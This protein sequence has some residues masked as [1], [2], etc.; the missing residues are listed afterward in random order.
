[1]SVSV[2]KKSFTI[3]GI[4]TSVYQTSRA[5]SESVAVVFLLHG[6]HGSAEDVASIATSFL[7]KEKTV[8][9]S[10]GLYVVTV[11]H[12]N[13]GGRIVEVRANNTWAEKNELHAMDM[14]SIQVGTARDI[15]FLCDFLPT[16]LFP[17]DECKIDAWGV[18]GISLGGHSTWLALS[19]DPRI[20]VGIPIIG[21]PDYMELMKY[22]A[23]SSG[24]SLEAPYMPASFS[25]LVESVDPA[26]KDFTSTKA[27][28]PFIGKKILVLSGEEDPL[29]PWVA[30]K[31][32]VERLEV[33]RA[34]S[35]GVSL[36]APYMPASFSKLVESVDPASK[37][38]TSTKAHNPFIGKKILVLSGEEDP[39]VPWVASKKFVERLEVG[40]QGSKRDI[41][42]DLV[43]QSN[44][45][46][47]RIMQKLLY[48]LSYD[49]K[50]TTE[51]WQT[52]LRKQYN[53]RDPEANP[54]GPEPNHVERG[55]KEE[56]EEP[57]LPE[58]APVEQPGQ[59]LNGKDL[60]EGESSTPIAESLSME[61]GTSETPLPE[62]A[63]GSRQS[64]VLET[65]QPATVE[66]S[67]HNEGEEEK[68]ST[69]WLDLPMLTKLESLHTLV[70]WQFQNPTRLRTI[71]K[72]DDELASWRVE[73]IGYDSKR[74]AYWFIGGERLWIQ[75]VPPKPPKSQASKR[76]RVNN[77]A[78]DKNTPSKT[79]PPPKKRARL[80]EANTRSNVAST[81]GRH[82]RAA[83]DQA[84]IKLDL[85]AKE[86][87]QLNREATKLSH[88]SKGSSPSKQP[89]RL[90]SRVVGTR[91]S[92]RLRGPLEDEWQPIPNEWLNSP[93]K[94]KDRNSVS[95]NLKTG[96]ESDEESDLT[97]LSEDGEGDEDEEEEPAEVSKPTESAT[98]NGEVAQNHESKVSDEKEQ[99][100]SQEVPSDFIEW[101]TLCVTLQEWEHIAERFANATYY[102]E[103]ALYKLL[104]N[105]IVPVIT[106]ELREIERKRELEE[107]LNH[108]KRSSRLAL[109]E[110]E[111]EEARLTAMRK[112][113][114]DEKFSRT[115]RMEAR[116]QKEEE[117]RIKRENA[118]EQRRKEREAREE[119][120]RA[121]TAQEN[122]AAEQAAKVKN[123]RDTKSNSNNVNRQTA[124]N[125]RNGNYSGSG[126]GSGSGSRTPAGE[127]WELSCEICHRH[128]IN[129]DDGTPMMSCGRCSKWQHILCHDRADQAAGRPRR[130]WDAVDFICKSCRTSQQDNHQRD[131][132]YLSNNT[133]QPM[134]TS[135]QMQSYRSY[136][137]VTNPQS[138]R[139][140]P[141]PDYRGAPQQ[142]SF[143]VRPPHG[144][145]KHPVQYGN[146][147]PPPVNAARPTISFSHYQPAAHGFSSGPQP[148]YTEP[149]SYY[150]AP[151]PLY[152]AAAAPPY[153]P[154]P[155]PVWNITTPAHAPGYVM[156]HNGAATSSNPVQYRN[157]P[158]EHRPDMVP[159]SEPPLPPPP[160]LYPRY[161]EQHYQYPQSNSKHLPTAYQPPLGR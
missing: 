156:P 118:R 5:L 44:T 106:H 46:I 54:L 147:P 37:D 116:Q 115:R 92:A 141:Y 85:Q 136:Q 78:A 71:M 95:K 90:S 86:L 31:K 1:M 49:R 72:S 161:P 32:F 98:V 10:R 29:V 111:R 27:H 157:S 60:L 144:Q 75:R 25:K 7:A 69:D 80:E 48:T 56:E 22:R 87:A 61:P 26:S 120:R 23:N 126:S 134:A 121:L 91:T 140:V 19:Q 112:Q 76:K 28:N 130:N 74:N 62:T 33:Y 119:S 30:S 20:Q 18:V 125:G 153:K 17:H 122:L 145:Q 102:T 139:H 123:I 42:R 40:A 70:E 77:K 150:G 53:K 146:T 131:R 127:D 63:Q 135:S 149:H 13:H 59:E 138:D 108:R 16:Y 109:R 21:C 6:R 34:N 57:A 124:A 65:S 96:L 41:E 64:S 24:V 14:Y 103:K 152:R 132:V 148:A 67:V 94:P 104:V 35:S 159:T 58:S 129:L 47:S 68:P 83:K 107:A 113:E 66:K 142:Q 100:D 84:K 99:K 15:T 2:I 110:S 154:Q 9:E 155:M 73:P 52:A 160:Q 105:D 79:N 11:D 36:E 88:K 117:E 50:V 93:A 4:Q 82:S 97:E 101:E 8:P 137:Q 128:G 43:H 51:N 158:H 39:L 55:T 89:S 143:Y 12:R 3:G 81:S 114:E 38:F 45:V 133:Q 151:N